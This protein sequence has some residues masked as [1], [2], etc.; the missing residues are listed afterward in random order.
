MAARA[1]LATPTQLERSESIMRQVMAEVPEACFGIVSF[2]HLA[3]P[4]TSL[5][6]DRIILEEALRYDT[7]VDRIPIRGSNI[8]NAL[9]VVLQ[10]IQE[11]KGLYHDVTHIVVFTDG[12]T[13][14][15]GYAKT[16][17]DFQSQMRRS[18]LKVTFVGIGS[19]EG[20]TIP[21]YD[22]QGL[23]TGEYATVD[24]V[25]Y[26]TFLQ[27]SFLRDLAEK[28]GGTY[29]PEV[30]ADELVRILR[31]EL[32][33]TGR[34]RDTSTTQDMSGIPYGFLSGVLL[35]VIWKKYL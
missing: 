3:F 18:S 30:E 31:S 23:F 17:A 26:F 13:P 8:F 1:N 16:V 20:A 12:G 34:S 32:A 2:T 24:G 21:L 29:L 9:G 4:T 27:E 5:T 14:P 11:P 33:S 28:F 19:T 35:F 25:R 7:E 6:C 22:S 15:P 10:R